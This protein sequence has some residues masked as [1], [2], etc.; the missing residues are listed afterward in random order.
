MLTVDIDKRISIE[1]ICSL[2]FL[3]FS[4]IDQPLKFKN[5]NIPVNAQRDSKFNQ[6]QIIKSL[7]GG[8][9][10]TA[11]LVSEKSTGINYCMKQIDLIEIDFT[12]DEVKKEVDL[13][14]KFQHPNIIKV[15]DHFVD[16][17][18]FC[19]VVEYVDGGDLE[20]KIKSQIEQSIPF[21]EKFILNV[22]SQLVSALYECKQKK[23]LHR[24]I[25][26]S[27]IFFTKEGQIKLGDFGVARSLDFTF[28][29]VST[30]AGTPSYMAPEIFQ[31]KPKYSF[32]ADVWSLGCVIYELMTLKPL[33]TGNL[34]D[35]PRKIIQGQYPPLKGNYSPQLNLLVN[36]MLTVD[37]SKRISI[38]KFFNLAFLPKVPQIQI[39]ENKLYG[40]ELNSLRLKHKKG[41]GVKVN[42]Q[43]AH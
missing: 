18:N 36:D 2:T 28:Q 29:Q 22:F 25:K 42:F 15:F 8:Q 4:S 23:V 3:K 35:L 38:E 40:K 37:L 9:F 6:Y 33:F 41:D 30:F 26:P 13:L 19:I 11:L 7:G 12:V 14:M 16:E 1:E 24:D 21:E 39:S 10:G 27:N 31:E 43:D 34:I 20:D 32:P 17:N 5:D